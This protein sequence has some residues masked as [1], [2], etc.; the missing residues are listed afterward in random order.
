MFS[1]FNHFKRRILFHF[2]KN[3]LILSNKGYLFFFDFI[4]D[5]ASFSPKMI[6]NYHHFVRQLFIIFLVHFIVI[7]KW[8][9]FYNFILFLTIVFGIVNN[10]FNSFNSANS[11]YFPIVFLIFLFEAFAYS[12]LVYFPIR[13]TFKPIIL[14][15]L[16]FVCN[17]FLLAS[18]PLVMDGFGF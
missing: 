2:I 8:L 13:L 14:G 4:V 16:L 3:T 5:L 1:N 6:R 7:L 12:F 15:D 18:Y 17:Y 10:R 11:F 9:L